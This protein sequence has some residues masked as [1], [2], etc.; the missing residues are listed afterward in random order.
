MVR[1]TTPAANALDVVWARGRR[2]DRVRHVHRVE[3][4]EAVPAEWPTWADPLVVAAFAQHGVHGLWQHQAEAAELV[5]AGRHTVVATGTA[6]GKSLAYLVPGLT[7]VLADA[8]RGLAVRRPTVLYL[9]PTKALAADQLARIDAL[10]IPGVRAATYDGDTSPDERRWVREHASFVLS[11]P[12]LLHHS[13][14]PGHERWARFLRGLELVVVDECHHYRGVFGSHVAAVLRRLR[15][16]AARYGAEPTFVLASATVSSPAEHA[17][18]L[19]GLPVT[20]VTRDGSPRGST[21]IVLWEPPLVPGGGEHDAPTRRSAAAEA[22]DLLTDLTTAGVRSLA[23]VRSRR[24]VEQVAATARR[25]LWEVDPELVDRVAAYRGGY[26]PEERRDLEAALR[27][28]RLLGLAATN[29]LELGVDIAGLD[30]VVIAGWP[31]RRTSMWQQVG[32]AGREGQDALGVLIAADDP[33]DTYLVEH[34]DAVFGPPMEATVLDPDNPYVL[35]P[36]LAAA[37]AELPVT[38]EDLALFG[39]G[40]RE[41]LDVLVDRGVLRRRPTGWFWPRQDRAAALADL[42]GTGGGTVRVVEE[43]TGRVL[44][45]VDVAAADRTVH[46]GAVY[47]HQGDTFVVR[48]LDLDQHLALVE[49]LAPP[50]TTH[51][52]SVTDI[53]LLDT[54]R[55]RRWG[56]IEVSFGSVRVTTQVVSFLRRRQISGEVL[57]EEPLDLPQRELVTKAVW[58]QTTPQVLER[59]DVPAADLPGALHAAE[60]AA[61]GLLPLLATCDRWDVGGV[62][63]ALHPDTGMPTVVVHDGHPGGAGFAERGYAVMRQWVQATHD[64]VRSCGCA[65]GCPSCVQSPKCGNGNEPLDKAGALRVLAMLIDSADD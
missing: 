48:R 60:H 43:E 17:G 54:L 61:I 57:G 4:R 24:G 5:H 55:S 49:R 56:E 31:G 2:D 10:S 44:G 11:N 9:S 46:A 3:R 62:S 34:P 21:D 29:A 25:L 13:M 19:T 39:P 33:L 37:A 64:A 52:R 30:A 23:F 47:V 16:V 40:T 7:T 42:R 65:S 1:P 32:R 18:R 63:T 50:W 51:A 45:T 36:H 26:L 15:R 6:S 59:W 35:A 41:L 38:E 27:S 20:G 22:A 8:G 53:R 14:L 58:W 12:D 28:G